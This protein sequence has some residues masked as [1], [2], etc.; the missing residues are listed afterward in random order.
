MTGFLSKLNKADEP[1]IALRMKKFPL[2]SKTYARRMVAQSKFERIMRL[3]GD[4][5]ITLKE[6]TSLRSGRTDFDWKVK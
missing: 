6:A 4:K 5:K 1:E 2:W 3:L